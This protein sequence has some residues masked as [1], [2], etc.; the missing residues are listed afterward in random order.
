[1]AMATMLVVGVLDDKYGLGVKLRF[2]IE[3][4]VVFLI[5]YIN[6]S[7]IDNFEGIWGV[8]MMEPWAV[9]AL[10]ILSGVGLMNAINLIDGVDGY[11]SGFSMVACIEFAL[12]FYISRVPGMG[13]ICLVCAGSQLP[14]FLHNVFGKRTKM[15]IGDGGTLMIGTMITAF[16]FSIIKHSSA[17]Y[18]LLFQEHG[19]ALIPL[20][21]AIMAIPVFD[22]L[23]V[24]F[25]R[26][27]K[28]RSPFSPDK[29][30]LHHAFIDL[31]YSHIGTTLKIIQINLAI[32]AGWAIAWAL[33]ASATLQLYVVA[34]LGVLFTFVLYP[35]LRA[36][37]KRRGFLSAMSAK[38]A[39]FS[40]IEN[41]KPW[42]W[43]Q[44][45]VD[46]ELFAEGKD[47]MF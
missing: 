40:H 41:S 8:D 18:K 42:R 22:T 10:S 19:V 45:L 7:A 25:T 17:S 30:H 28:G 32:L 14:F 29:T 33:G 2:A 36:L 26:A 46:D 21:L 6:T 43:M 38:M 23:R 34:A 15:F 47:E 37:Q 4:A 35:V 27:L 39:A 20:C 31:G 9:Y 1:M 13:I 24:M 16:C 44:K 11:S 5:I 12:V 3:I